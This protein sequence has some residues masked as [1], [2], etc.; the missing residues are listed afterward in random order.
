MEVHYRLLDLSAMHPALL[1]D[2]IAT[3]TAAVLAARG[4][5]PYRFALRVEGFAHIEV[6]EISLL[7]DPD[8]LSTDSIA[9]IARTYEPHRLIELAAIAVAA[10]GLHHAGGHEIID[11]AVRGSSA[12]YLVG[13]G[14]H[15][16]EVAGRSR[17]SD[18]ASAWQQKLGRLKKL[19]GIGFMLC[20]AEFESP[21]G[22]LAFIE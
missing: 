8:G 16:L 9:R 19:Y 2:T 1:W 14:R 18:F 20:V 22:K 10:C 13:V 12:D 17:R 4:V 5:P 3:A 21:A 6:S 7:L 11:L 15:H